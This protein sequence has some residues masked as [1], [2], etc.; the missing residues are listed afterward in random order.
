M[1]KSPIIISDPNDSLYQPVAINQTAVGATQIV[2]LGGYDML[3]CN[4]TGSGFKLTMSQNTEPGSLDFNSYVTEFGGWTSKSGD[5]GAALHENA[6]VNGPCFVVAPSQT[7]G[8]VVMATAEG[9]IGAF[10]TKYEHTGSNPNFWVL[11]D[12]ERYLNGSKAASAPA[13]ALSLQNG[14]LVLN[15]VWMDAGAKQMVLCQLEVGEGQASETYRYL[16]ESCIGPPSLSMNGGTSF[17]S[18]FGTDGS[19]NLAVDPAGGVDFQFDRK[20]VEPGVTSDLGPCIVPI[21]RTQLYVV[22]ADRN[23]QGIHYAQLARD[24]FGQWVFNPSKGCS[25]LVAG[26][27]PLNGSPYAHFDRAADGTPLLAV[28]WPQLP[29]NTVMLTHVPVSL[30]PV[31]LQQA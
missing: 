6:I 10:P 13:A 8:Y 29:A 21:N 25:G 2:N 4:G 24:Q 15:I 31:P 19:F 11:V 12:G 30:A 22:W 18:W 26:A 9:T 17:L 27:Y 20:V 1:P 14:R 28:V 3:L 23:R 7:Q 16:G 5:P